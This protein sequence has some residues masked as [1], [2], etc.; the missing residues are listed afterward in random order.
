MRVLHIANFSL[1]K[2]GRVF[3]STDRKL[4]AGFTRAGHFVYDIS[5]RDM[6]RSLSPF[7]SKK[8]GRGKLNQA[9]LR[10]VANLQ[11][12]LL[13]LGHTDL[14]HEATL[15]EARRLAPGLRIAQ[16]FVDWLV[17]PR[18][19]QH[20]FKRLPH[21]D[22]FF[23]TT[24]GDWLDPLRAINPNCH[25]LPNPVDP[26]VECLCNDQVT[27]FAY[28]LLYAGV[29]YKDPTRTTLL[30]GLTD[31][32]AFLRF[33][34]RG[35]LGKPAVYGA[36]YISLLSKSKM[37]LNLSRRHDIP[38]YSSDRIAQLTGNGLLTFMPQTPGFRAL[39]TDNEIVYFDDTP[40]LMEKALH[41]HKNDDERRAMAWRGRERAHRSYGAARIAKF[42]TEMSCNVPPSEA[43]EWLVT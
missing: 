37:A 23:C 10:T 16:W 2:D 15:D 20:L 4:S 8:L 6:A 26:A 14:L 21:L 35:S 22:A 28:D 7:G 12:E 24:G 32:A 30:Q 31:N 25:F 13:L 39:F 36:E 42:I 3:Y 9:V 34:V 19:R 11:P 41:Y 29:D 17:Y 38:Y 40:D 43:Y 18:D 5:D 33:E 1:G 27:D